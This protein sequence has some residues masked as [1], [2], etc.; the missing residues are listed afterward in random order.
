MLN[1]VFWRE[2]CLRERRETEKDL[3]EMESTEKIKNRRDLCMV[4]I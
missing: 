1:Q 3:L 4:D 2:I